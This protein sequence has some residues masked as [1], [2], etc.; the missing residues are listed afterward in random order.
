MLLMDANVLVYAIN[1]VAPQHGSSRTLVQAA[2]DGRVPGVLVPQVLLECFATVSSPRRIPSPVDAPEAWRWVE[3]LRTGLPVLEVRPEALMLL[4]Q[5]LTSRP[6]RG[7]AIF[8][9]FLA[10]QMRSHGVGT[11]CTYNVTDFARLPGIEAL[12]PE[13][14]LARYD[15]HE[16]PD[17]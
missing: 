15:I 12:T 14:V 13:E 1:T 11:I 9:L 10:A 16:Q 7:S 6:V 8:D 17:H 3:I 5:L 2:L 4:G